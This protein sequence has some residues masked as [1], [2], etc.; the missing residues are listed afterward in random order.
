MR[1]HKFVPDDFAVQ[2]F[3]E[4]TR[5]EREKMLQIFPVSRADLALHSV[6]NF[7]APFFDQDRVPA[8]DQQA[9]LGFGP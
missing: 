2:F 5:R 8:L 6:G 3:T 4:R 7:L 9:R 1:G